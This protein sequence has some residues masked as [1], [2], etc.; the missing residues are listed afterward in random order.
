MFLGTDGHSSACSDANRQMEG[1]RVSVLVPQVLSGVS[2]CPSQG[3]WTERMRGE[4]GQVDTREA[5]QPNQVS[6]GPFKNQGLYSAPCP[7]YLPG[8]P[9][10]A[11][12]RREG[13]KL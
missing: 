7:A 2:S 8:Q 12:C 1:A 3:S 10:K 9:H 4:C 6:P 11:G 13:R 5:T